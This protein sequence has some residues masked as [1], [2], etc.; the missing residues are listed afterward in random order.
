MSESQLVEQK[1]V[2]RD[3][4]SKFYADY[5]VVL[6]IF[7]PPKEDNKITLSTLEI[8]TLAALYRDVPKFKHISSLLN[9]T[10]LKDYII[11]LHNFCFIAYSLGYTKSK[12]GIYLHRTHATVINS[13]RRV[14]DG[15]DTND[16]F[17]IDVYNNIIT[18]LENYVGTIPESL[19]S[20]DDPEPVTDTIWDQARRL[21]A[22]YN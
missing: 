14:S 13:C 6:H 7:I 15:I 17:T 10:R 16:K 18:E 12:I 9:R 2:I 8:V 22:I 1:E 11:Y 3:F 21:L 20:K 19:K 5:G 4:K